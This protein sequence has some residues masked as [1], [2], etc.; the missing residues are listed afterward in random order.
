MMMMMMAGAGICR[1]LV[2]TFP[3]N[4]SMIALAGCLAGCLRICRMMVP[5]VSFVFLFFAPRLPLGACGSELAWI[6]YCSPEK[7]VFVINGSAR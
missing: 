5:R 3:R 4:H 6:L 2:L 7:A 1:C